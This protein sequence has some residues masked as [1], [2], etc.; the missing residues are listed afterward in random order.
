MNIPKNQTDLAKMLGIAKSAVCSQHK[1]G[2]P[3]TSLEEA[4]AWRKSNLDP[5]KRKGERFDQYRKPSQHTQIEAVNAMLKWADFELQ[6]GR[7]IV[8]RALEIGSSMRAVPFNLRGQIVATKRSTAAL[9]DFNL[10]LIHDPDEQQIDDDQPGGFCDDDR[11]FL[12]ELRYS[13]S[14]GELLENHQTHT[15]AT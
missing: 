4:Q 3:V 11:Q 2:M 5:A 14:C 9:T 1:R 8:A 6:N 7:Q 15:G 10:G 13:L 12:D